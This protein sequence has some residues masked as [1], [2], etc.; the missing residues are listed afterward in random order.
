MTWN[1]DVDL[2]EQNAN[3]SM[4]MMMMMMIQKFTNLGIYQIV[5]W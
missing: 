2:I 4:M 1:E 5:E 3:I